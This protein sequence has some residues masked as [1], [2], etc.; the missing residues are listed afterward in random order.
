MT[1]V[2]NPLE[3]PTRLLKDRIGCVDVVD[4]EGEAAVRQKIGGGEVG[5]E[6]WEGCSGTCVFAHPQSG[7]VAAASVEA[8]VGFVDLWEVARCP[9]VRHPCP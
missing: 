2:I 4:D 8:E 6:G 9:V 1:T 7:K 3:C 5:V